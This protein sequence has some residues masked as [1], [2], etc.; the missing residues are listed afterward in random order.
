[1]A[2]IFTEEQGV[3]SSI[4]SSLVKCGEDVHKSNGSPYAKFEAVG[5]NKMCTNGL[6]KSQEADVLMKER[7]EV[8]TETFLVTGKSY[9]IRLSQILL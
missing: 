4:D 3:Q 9:C 8:S 7:K 1:M 6:G 2:S 5:E